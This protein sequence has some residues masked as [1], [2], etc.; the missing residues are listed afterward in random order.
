MPLVFRT[1]STFYYKLIIKCTNQRHTLILIYQLF[2]PENEQFFL[3]NTTLLSN[4]IAFETKQDRIGN[5]RPPAQS[6]NVGRG[7]IFLVQHNCAKQPNCL[8]NEAATHRLFKTSRAIEQCRAIICRRLLDF[9]ASCC[10]GC[11]QSP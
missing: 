1:L 3:Y 9:M 10:L 6:N 8:R 4:T 11:K 2:A 5:L 7:S